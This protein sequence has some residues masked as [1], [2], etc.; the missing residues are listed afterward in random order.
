MSLLSPSS[1]SNQRYNFIVLTLD[2]LFF[3]LGISYYSATTILPLFVSHLTPSNLVVGAVP[4]VVALS[5]SLPQL[6]GARALRNLAGR[7]AAGG[8]S[9]SSGS[10][11]LGETGRAGRM[12]RPDA[13]KRYIIQT[14]LLGRVPMLVLVAVTALYSVSHP[15]LTLVLFLLCFGLFRL[16]GGL[17][18]PVYY[19]LVAVVIHPRIRAR[20]IGLSQFLGGAIAAVALATGS[21]VLDSFPFPGGF[22]ILFTVGLILMTGAIGFMAIVREPD[23]TQEAGHAPEGSDDPAGATGGAGG[24]GSTDSGTGIVRAAALTLKRDAA[25]RGYLGGRVFVAL[26]SMAQAFYAIHA[27]R[28]MGGTDGD[29]A[30]FSAILLG[31]QTVSTLVW[32]AVADRL[33]LQPVLLAATVLGALATGIALAA[34]SLAWFGLVFAVSGAAL[35]A[36]AVTDPGMPLALAERSNAD[37]ALYVAVANT[38]LA[39]VYVVAPLVGGAAADTGGYAL[40]YVAALAAGALACVLVARMRAG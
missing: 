37:R 7:S 32:G 2:G 30:F 12:A 18:T 8:S 17:N 38:V 1:L 40:T 19:D 27:T 5:W 23:F 3:W 10:S 9:G 13:R 6:F 26:A 33:H 11:G 16:A 15:T 34:P 36:L 25:F 22:V 39:P 35:G 21:A 20:F 14:A 28:D 4:A 29:V 31:S 24:T